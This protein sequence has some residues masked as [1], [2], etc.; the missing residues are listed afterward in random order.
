MR[1]PQPRLPAA[2]HLPLLPRVGGPDPYGPRGLEG[3]QDLEGAVAA[4]AVVR[5]AREL[6]MSGRAA[7]SA[8]GEDAVL[9]GAVATDLEAAREQVFTRTREGG[10]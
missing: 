2:Q 6:G 10:G 3:Q 1:P 8:L 9:L 5:A 7:A 4:E